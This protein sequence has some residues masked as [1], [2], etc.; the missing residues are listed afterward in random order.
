[1]GLDRVTFDPSKYIFHPGLVTVI[2][3]M[4]TVIKF[5][6][7]F[8]CEIPFLVNAKGI[9]ELNDAAD[10]NRFWLSKC[11]YPDRLQLGFH[12]CVY[13]LRKPMRECIAKVAA[14]RA[15]YEQI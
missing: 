9:Q 4:I 11:Q 1:M 7:E 14:D 12:I 8:H 5:E 13:P 6:D 2:A 15:T 10:E 3:K